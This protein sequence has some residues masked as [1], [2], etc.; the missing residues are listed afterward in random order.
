MLAS[1]Y[2]LTKEDGSPN[3]QGI[4][5]VAKVANW[6]PGGGVAKTPGN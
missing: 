6:K 1:E 3:E 2:G 5:E 4:D